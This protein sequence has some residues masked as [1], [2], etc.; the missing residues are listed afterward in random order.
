MFLFLF[1]QLRDILLYY[2]GVPAGVIVAIIVVVILVIV[3][4]IIA[5]IFITRWYMKKKYAMKE[6]V[7]RYVLMNSLYVQR[8]SGLCV[9]GNTKCSFIVSLVMRTK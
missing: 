6:N 2:I 5:V 3:G 1:I 8:H 9:T 7:I 4:V